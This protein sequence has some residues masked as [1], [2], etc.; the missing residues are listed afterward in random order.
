MSRA[1]IDAVAQAVRARRSA[2]GLRTRLEQAAPELESRSREASTLVALLQ[3][4][5]D[6]AP[7]E[8]PQLLAE[9]QD[10]L[11][12][13]ASALSLEDLASL[14]RVLVP[15][16]AASAQRAL[17]SLAHRPYLP[18]PWRK[19]F[20]SPQS[21]LML[22][23]TRCRWLLHIALLLGDYDADIRWIAA[24]GA[25]LA[26]WSGGSDI[27][28]LLAG[29]IDA[30]GADGDEVRAILESSAAGEHETGQ[31]GRHVT[32]A[33]LSCSRPDAWE[34]VV[35]LLLAAQRQ[36]GLRQAIL[37]SVDE[38]HPRAFRRMLR[39]IRE[40]NLARFSATVRAFDV[41]FGF[42]WDGASAIKVNDAIDRVALFLDDANAR[43]A[44]LDERD[45]ETVYLALWSTG[46]EDVEA[47][48]PLAI[49][50]LSAAQAERRFVAAH[51]LAQTD[52]TTAMP[53]LVEALS[54]RDLRV[55]ARGLDAF[56]RDVTK[57]VDGPRLFDALESLLAR[58]PRRTHVLPAIVWPWTSRKLERYQVAAAMIA[59]AE[60]APIERLLPYVSDLNARSRAD[61]LAVRTGVSPGWGVPAAHAERQPL[62]PQ[63][64]R[65]VIEALGDAS[66]DVR[67]VAFEA[68]DGS[69]VL[70]D[71]ITRLTELLGRIAGDL[72]S[73]ALG[74][75]QTLGNERLDVADALLR[76]ASEPRRMAGLELLR[77]YVE[78]GPEP[79]AARDR[80]R[81]YASGRILSEA[82]RVHVE[83][84][85]G[86]TRAATLDDALG[87]VEPSALRQ[88]PPPIA[89]AIALHTA[90]AL[91]CVEA[92]AALATEHQ[93]DE[94]ESP[95]GDRKLLFEAGGHCWVAE[96]GANIPG[97]A[98]TFPLDAMWKQWLAA[99]D[100]AQR[101]PDGLELVRALLADRESPTWS[102]PH[103][104]QLVREDMWSP[105]EVFLRTLLEW[106][107]VWHPPENAVVFLLDGLESSLARMTPGD[108]DLLRSG[109]PMP[110][111]GLARRGWPEALSSRSP[112]EIAPTTWYDRLCWHRRCCPAVW[113]GAHSARLYALLRW[114]QVQSAGFG[115]LALSLRLVLDAVHAGAVD[116]R[117][118]VD[119][120]VGRWSRQ[121]GLHLL[122]DVSARTP[123]PELA[124]NASLL[125]IVDRCRRRLVEVECERG[126]RATAATAAVFD[127]RW[128]GG[129]ETLSQA[130]L[131]L[132]S[133]KLARTTS[134]RG[135]S[136]P[137]ALSHLVLRSTPQPAD[138]P[139]AF[140]AWAQRARIR[141]KRLIELA[142][143]APQW[144]GH[145]NHVLG[146]EGFESGVWWLHAHTKDDRSWSLGEMKEIWA[147]EV[148]ERTPLTPG[149]LMEGA[150]DVAWFRDVYARLGPTRWAE[151]D[152][153]AKYGASS[154][155]HTRAQL[156]ARAI[157]GLVGRDE[158]VRRIDSPRHQD[159]V[160]ALGLLPLHPGDEGRQDLHERYARLQRF[161]REAGKF[162]SQRQQSEKRAVE[163]GLANLARTAGYRDPRRLQWAM[164]REALADLLHGPVRL[165]RQE[166]TLTL[167]ID[168][169]GEPRLKAFRADTPL[170]AVPSALRRDP[171]YVELKERLQELR[172]QRSRVKGALEEAMCRGD[173]FEP[174]ELRTLLEHPILAP[175]LARLLLIAGDGLA[176][177]PVDGG[178]ALAGP[179]GAARALEDD[180]AVRIAHPH[181][182]FASG[183]W[184]DWQREC[185]RANRTQ[186]FK[187]VFREL[188]PITDS[189]R[190]ASRSRRYAGHQ[191]NP[192]QGLSLLGGRGW[193]AHPEQGVNRTFHSEGMT[194]RLT[195]E[196]AFYTPAD[197]EGLTLDD[198]VFTRKGA[199]EALPLA[200][201]PPRVFSEAMRDLDLLVSVAHRGGVD[202][203]ATASTVAMRAAL[204]GETC[205]ALALTTVEVKG[206]HAIVRGELASYA[207]HLG[208]A[209]VTV[210]PGTALFIVA[211]HSQHRGRLFLPFADDD[212]R[213]AEVI[214]KVLLLARDRQI[215]D[216]NILDQIRLAARG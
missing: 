116:D 105:G 117:E 155:G 11:G 108:F 78:N 30:G 95:G 100:A 124:A 113:T 145:V 103:A 178:R 216:P 73:R 195:F 157:A 72:R 32:Q 24:H 166:V 192:R 127:L 15:G 167:A 207:V 56:T 57:I 74:R 169:D 80:V 120:L 37:E 118:F 55:A 134:W 35:R 172:Q 214:S 173:E 1:H 109:E 23:Y 151:L 84:V 42:L 27:G 185:F 190:Q 130:L 183:R 180:R 114:F 10:Q 96:E 162:G 93:N 94:I 182:L 92:L 71:E 69:P 152:A 77:D 16:I 46:F 86:G 99:R 148:S 3:Q 186:P 82:A 212:P 189:E 164:E 79:G 128:T 29:A 98:T 88:W 17:T 48:I 129:L 91:A 25:H 158:M 101:D 90:G 188:Y 62:T 150:V 4:I 133:S 87:L 132:G 28:W 115:A 66:P 143:Y 122:R 9:R 206:H 215:K 13:L 196:E 2:N 44:A 49:P 168:A 163:I 26:G 104:R 39:A 70:S 112:G 45:A 33:L 136:R 20:R 60:A 181:D 139:D 36:E 7:F 12:P 50:L 121:P 191:I 65:L 61:F 211:V 110:F 6:A 159:S 97:R 153:A 138:T 135:V 19:P 102:G 198:V 193:V 203:E 14:V 204:V 119:L 200:D 187:Q 47:A 53:A 177:Y 58:V 8:R 213:T 67:R 156:F 170:A 142:S 149:D 34:F 106:C 146:W 179:D 18:E 68:L 184:S 197:I 123:P 140:A 141:E 175:A 205:A 107:V 131:A 154:G 147:A 22:G 161:R 41:W 201:I 209:N 144:A 63:L 31:M 38:A 40:E 126:D 51:F 21:G 76:D 194:A 81:A 54:D 64:R 75:L 208:S 5:Q 171:G 111:V 43:A 125:S 137:E 165:Q 59:N 85:L 199:W 89:K 52:W 202:P 83:A 210:L 176:G 160:R 174:S